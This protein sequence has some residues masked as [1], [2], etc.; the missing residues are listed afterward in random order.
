MIDGEKIDSFISDALGG[1]WI[2]EAFIVAL[3]I[4]GILAMVS[5]AAGEEKPKVVFPCEV[6]DVYDG[7]TMTVRITLDV[8][9]RLLDC[10][11]HEVRHRNPEVKKL[12]Q[13]SKE[14]LARVAQPGNKAS[15]E[16][17]LSGVDRLDDVFTFGRLLCHVV[18][19]GTSLS[20][21]QVESGHAYESK[22]LLQESL[23]D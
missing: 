9:V 13:L 5:A 19:D 8:R 16:V 12:G 4:F 6:V 14:N 1:Y 15:I 10:W 23:L 2:R 17:P 7:D 18:V 3:S 21:H 11:A 22:E 20:E